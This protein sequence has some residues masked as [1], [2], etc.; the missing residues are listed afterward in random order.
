MGAQHLDRALTAGFPSLFCARLLNLALAPAPAPSCTVSALAAYQRRVRTWLDQP[1]R[2]VSRRNARQTKATAL[3][4]RPL[5]ALRPAVRCPT[6]RYNTKIREGRGFTLRELKGAGIG[7][8]EAKGLG[9]SVDHRRRGGAVE[10]EKLNVERLQAYRSRLIVF[11]R[12]AGKPKKGDS[13]DA[14]LSAETTSAAIPL[15]TVYQA[16]APR[17]ITAEEKEFNAYK[18]LRD[19]RAHKRSFGKLKAKAECV[20]TACTHTTRA[21]RLLTSSLL[22]FPSAARRPLRRPTRPRSKATRFLTDFMPTLDDLEGDSGDG[23][24]WAAK[25][26]GRRRGPDAGLGRM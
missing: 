25:T 5:K 12:K 22:C 19:A 24:R 11:P 7:K 2:K 23:A 17:A 6:V 1:G 20:L 13:T 18:T 26:R 16:E 4:V 8:K 14:E 15:P 9:I 21:S 3:G 10:A